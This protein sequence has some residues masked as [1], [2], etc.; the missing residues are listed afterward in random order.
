[1]CQLRQYLL[2]NLQDQLYQLHLFFL[3]ALLRR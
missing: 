2:Q 3:F 1:M